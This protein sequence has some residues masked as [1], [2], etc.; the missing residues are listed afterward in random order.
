MLV[1]CHQGGNIIATFQWDLGYLLLPSTSQPIWLLTTVA[2]QVFVLNYSFYLKV[3]TGKKGK[4]NVT[5][6]GVGQYVEDGSM[7]I[8]EEDQE[9][10]VGKII[11]MSKDFV[12]VVLYNGDITGIWSQTKNGNEQPITK[13]FEI[14]T[15]QDDLLFRLTATG[16]LPAGIRALL[17]TKI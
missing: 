9:W 1:F 5:T 10:Y 2:F 13:R 16:K 14:N 6:S 3:Y 7:I 15:V 12:D 4:S 17:K 8:A 11:R